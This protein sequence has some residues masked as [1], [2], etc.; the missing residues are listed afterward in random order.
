MRKVRRIHQ[1]GHV[2]SLLYG[3]AFCSTTYPR[4]PGV[5]VTFDEGDAYTF[6][7][8]ELM[9]LGSERRARESIRRSIRDCAHL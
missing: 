4:D 3:D 6:R 5:R 8:E 7:P 2:H 1:V 9:S